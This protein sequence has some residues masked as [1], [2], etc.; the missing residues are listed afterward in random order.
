MS[1]PDLPYVEQHRGD[2]DAR[3]RETAE[4]A[5]RRRK[6][7]EAKRRFEATIAGAKSRAALLDRELLGELSFSAALI[8]VMAIVN[9]TVEIKTA[10]EAAEVARALVDIGRLERG[11]PSAHST[12]LSPEERAVRIE[13]A[14][15]LRDE[16]A[17]RAKVEQAELDD[18]LGGPDVNL[19][20]TGS[21]P[22]FVSGGRW[23]RSVPDVP[24]PVDSAE[25]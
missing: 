12:Q 14:K 22:P 18:T 6:G 24:D 17:E 16:L 15:R 3:A 7:A 1:R 20:P 21:S 4:A 9:G 25:V 5:D 19:P 23:P 10:K 8:A 13:S 11:D 2:V